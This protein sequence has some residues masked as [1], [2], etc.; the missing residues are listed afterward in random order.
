[1]KQIIVLGG[2]Y[3]GVLTAKKLANKLRKNKD[4]R[5]TLIDRKPYHTLLTEL[6]EVA[7]NRVEEDSIRIDLK[8]IFSGF[9]NVEVV[10]DHIE[11]I[12]FEAQKLTGLSQSYNYDYLVIGTGS[13][14]TFF[15]IKGAQE[16]AFSLWSYEDAVKLKEHALHMFREAVKQPDPQVRQEMLTFVVVGGGFTGVE[17]IGELAEYTQEL[18]KQFYVDP[19]EVSL[20]VAD[21]VDTILPILP[22][23]LIEK[24]E[25]RLHKLG[26][27]I[28]TGAKITE[29]A[30]NGVMVG[31]SFISSRT[32]IWTAGVEGSD[33]VGEL[34]VEKQGRQRIV[35]NDKLQVPEH[36]NVYV[37]GDNIFYIPEGSERPVPQMVENAELAAPII[38]HNIAAEFTSLPKKSYKPTFHGT[39]VCIGSKYG[40]AS[41]GTPKKMYSLSGFPAM[42]IKH[43]IN[44]L[45]LFQ[46]C[47]FNKVYHYIL[48]EFLN[49]K[50]NRSF[51]GGHF[52]KRSPNF[53]LVPLRIFAGWMWFKQGFDKMG[54]ILDDPGAMFLIPAKAVDGTS[55][56]SVADTA[57]AVSAA[58]SY[59]SEALTALPVPDFMKSIVDWSMD[60]MFYSSDGGYTTLAYIFQTG[61]VAAELLVGLLL[62]VGLF[63]APAAIVSLCMGV[64]VWVSGMAPSEMLW[65]LAA[66]IALIGGSGSTLGLDYYVYPRLK[67]FWRRLPLVRRWYLYTD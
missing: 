48:H 60:L 42:G 15:G 61:M 6:H 54:K 52:A 55:G 33:L 2:G 53:W 24:A 12:D 11:L 3:G 34:D 47:G 44:M 36:T 10:L 7:A 8:K 35:T 27:N 26:V 9:R 23:K 13:K 38:A 66:S 29:V 65:Y 32:V 20:H 5:I 17:M 4:V 43:L 16:H 28:I 31:D 50:N 64:M 57:D 45:Y 49:V 1:M 62:I 63:T 46:V 67:K 41:V 14:P 22:K 39:M 56:A 30:E 40:V 58:S 59:S 18:C 19:A 37:V 21:M 25:R 51:V